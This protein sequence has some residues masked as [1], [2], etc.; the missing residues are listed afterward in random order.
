MTEFIV[1]LVGCVKES[2]CIKE[3]IPDLLGLR[4]FVRYRVLEV[5][6]VSC[7]E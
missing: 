2:Y 5:Y 1:N 3:Q 4:I 7:V 6:A